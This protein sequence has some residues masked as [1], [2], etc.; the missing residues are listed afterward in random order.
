MPISFTCPHCDLRTDVADR[1]A[2]Q[3]GNCVACGK[4]ISI[5]L[6]ERHA[7]KA[8]PT[9]ARSALGTVLL[10]T[11]TLLVGGG[12]IAIL[13]YLAIA[14][15]MPQLLP[16]ASQAK[17]CANNMGLLADA[18][19]A[20]VND[21]GTYPPAYTTDQ[22]GQPLHSW[23]VLIL[24]YLG[25]PELYEQ[26][27][28][29]IPWDSPANALLA[30][31]MPS[32]YRCPSDLDLDVLET[33]YLGISG[34]RQQC[35]FDQDH[36]RLPSELKDGAALTVMITEATG[37][38]VHWM[39][40]L[41]LDPSEFVQWNAASYRGAGSMHLDKRFLV[42]TADGKVHALPPTSLS[43]EL[44]ALVTIAGQES[45]YPAFETP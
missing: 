39:E 29:T 13:T 34:T 15:Q 10:A 18:I 5:P 16:G 40:P 2:G 36:R 38:G 35:F 20:Y 8:P 3:S 7:S 25:Y 14:P 45:V 41:D 9:Q 30:R 24:P 43:D 32:E 37:M 23:R 12:I 6:S 28:L 26:I 19:L 4:S 27:D 22:Y 11:A 33:S 42:I 31:Q 44:S 17:T 21:H 1:F